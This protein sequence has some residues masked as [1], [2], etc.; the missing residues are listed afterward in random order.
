[1]GARGRNAWGASGLV[2]A[3]LTS[4]ASGQAVTVDPRLMVERIADGLGFGIGQLTSAF[5]VLDRNTI[6][7]ASRIDGKIRRI[8]LIP[9]AAAA[10]GPVVVDLDIVAN[11]QADSQSE[12]GVQSITPHPGFATNGWVYLRYDRSLT[13]GADTPETT[14]A[15]T[16]V[17]QSVIERWIWQPLANGGNG[18]L[19]FDRLIRST[20]VYERYHHGGPLVFLPD[21]TFVASLGDQR[22]GGSVSFNNNPDF[23]FEAGVLLR[24]NDDG[25]VPADNP[26]V[27]VPGLPASVAAWYAYGVRNAYGFATDPATGRLWFTDNGEFTF[28]ELNLAFPGMNSGSRQIAGPTGHPAQTG[29]TANLVMLPGAQY[30]EPAFSWRNT[31]GITGIAFLYGSA[32][33]PAWDDVLLAGMFNFGY[34]WGFRMTPDRLSLALSHPGLQDRVDDRASFSTEPVGTEAAELLFG[35]NFGGPFVSTVQA[36]MGPDG[37]PYFLNGQGKIWRITRRCWSD[38]VT[39]GTSDLE[40]GP[41]G[42]LTGDDFDAFIEAFFTGARRQP[43]GTL[44]ADVATAPTGAPFPDGF[45][46]GDDFD[47]FVYTFFTGCP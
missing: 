9:G 25:S 29:S 37:L 7:V 38:I 8:N 31:V 40:S 5:A 35:R 19:V 13:P 1:M 4:A 20:P 32:L 6:L 28:D 42:Y 27:G 24:L 3:A 47:R 45:L 18:A 41:D 30:A 39:A 26:F 12:Y 15:I 44:L 10:A 23:N 34:V 17:P 21:G 11:N 2:L 43:G 22:L 46:T 36:T 33:G 14:L 16:D